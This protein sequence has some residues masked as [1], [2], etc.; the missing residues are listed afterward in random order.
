MLNTT[1]KKHKKKY[2]EL[3]IGVLDSLIRWSKVRL[4][5]KIVLYMEIIQSKG[6]NNPRVFHRFFGLR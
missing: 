3:A 6:E 1:I 2:N 4:K 5:G